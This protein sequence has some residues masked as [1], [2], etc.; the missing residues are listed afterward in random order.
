[1]V[2]LHGVREDLQPQLAAATQRHG[3]VLIDMK[4]DIEQLVGDYRRF[5]VWAALG[6]AALII[7]VLAAALRDMRAVARITVA[8]A[9]AVLV[10]A[11][12]L[13]IVEGALTLFHLVALLLVVGC[14]SNYAMFFA[15]LPAEPDARH[16]TAMSVL[17][18]AATTFTAFALLAASATPVLHMIGLTVSVGAVVTLFAAAAWA[19]VEA[20]GVPNRAPN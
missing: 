11:A 20:P 16:A 13:V 2:T 12:V 1:L 6:G 4:G 19:D 15:R 3:A 14:G 5:A 9:T 7:V 8:L 10:T 17:L 18:A